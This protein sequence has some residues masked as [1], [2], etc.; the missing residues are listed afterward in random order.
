MPARSLPPR[1]P[2]THPPRPHH[3]HRAAGT[4][5]LQLLLPYAGRR[6]ALPYAGRAHSIRFQL[7]PESAHLSGQSTTTQLSEPRLTTP[8][9]G[10]A[11]PLQLLFQPGTNILMRNRLPISAS[12]T[13]R[14]PRGHLRCA[15]GLCFAA[16]R[17]APAPAHSPGP[18]PHSNPRGTRQRGGRGQQPRHPVQR[19]R[20]GNPAVGSRPGRGGR[21]FSPA[22]A[23]SS[24]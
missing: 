16:L 10:E 7:Q 9:V 17:S 22:S 3:L 6:V 18:Q 2:S 13:P 4:V 15:V 8:H 12:S 23:P 14:R 11:R 24:S 21:A 20:R 1:P 19:H 5:Q